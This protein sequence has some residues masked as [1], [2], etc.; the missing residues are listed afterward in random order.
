MASFWKCKFPMTS[1]SDLDYL[2]LFPQNIYMYNKLLKEHI[3]KK[4]HRQKVLGIHPSKT[5]LFT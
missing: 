2:D 3:K 5:K 4:L 1:L